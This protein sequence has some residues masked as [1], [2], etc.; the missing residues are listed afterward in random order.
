MPTLEL[1][2]AHAAYR[3]HVDAGALADLG[4]RTAEVAPGPRAFVVVDRNVES[5][6]GATVA[7]S[8]RAASIEPTVALIDAV[9]SAKSLE[10]VRALYDVMLTERFE[11]RTPVIAVGGGITGD[12]AGFVAAT[13]LRGVPV[14]QVPTTLLAM[15]DAS[16]GGKTGVNI[17]LPQRDVLGKNL[18]GAFWQPSAIVSDPETLVT[19]DDR[20]LRNGLA[21]SLKHAV[22]ADASLLEMMATNRAAYVARD[23]EAL[24]TLIHHS[25]AIKVGIVQD[26]EREAGGR[27]ALNLGHTFAHAI[28]PRPELELYHGEAVAIGMCAAAAVATA[29]GRLS[30]DDHDAIIDAITASGL[31]TTLSQPVP[32]S[33]LIDAMGYDKKVAGGAIRLVLPTAIGA[34]KVGQEVPR[35]VLEAGWRA[36]G[37][38]RG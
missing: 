28:E 20:Q 11:R 18:I 34:V 36:V 31:P 7:A 19:L 22:I 2:L 37:S 38:A 1:T 17:D 16:I 26:D 9:E 4:A 23:A 30:A 14:I 25:A 12:V 33:V 35:D 24:T 8:L 15:V 3:I 10:T 13:Y 6:H 21:E 32:A 5:T 27:A 29:I